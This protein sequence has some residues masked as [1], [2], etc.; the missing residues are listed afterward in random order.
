MTLK[1]LAAVALLLVLMAVFSSAQENSCLVE[2]K[3]NVTLMSVHDPA[4]VLLILNNE[5]SAEDCLRRCCHY[6][7]PDEGIG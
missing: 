3:Y 6:A 2:E 4:H 1:N 5:T 7:G